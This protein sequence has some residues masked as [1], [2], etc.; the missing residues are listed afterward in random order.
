MAYVELAR[1]H[2]FL[3]STLA[4]MVGIFQAWAEGYYNLVL[5]A[6]VLVGLI[7]HHAALESWDELRDYANYRSELVTGSRAPPT[8]FSGGSG[9]LTG[10]LL[11]VGQVWCFFIAMAVVCTLVLAGIIAYTGWRVLL[12]VAL[13]VF[14]MGNYNSVLKLSYRGFGELANFVSFGPIVVCSAYLVLRLGASGPH[15]SAHGWDLLSFLSW[16]VVV[17]S[18]VLGAVWLG[19]EHIQG[20][21]D[22]EEDRAGGKQTLVVRFGKR[23]AAR[24]PVATAAAIVLLT[25][26]LSSVDPG[27]LVVLPA[28]VLHLCETVSFMRLWRDDAYFMR[29]L[30]S[31]FVYRNFALIGLS[32]LLSFFLRALPHAGAG[33][34]LPPLVVLT[35]ASSIPA[36]AFL[37]RN[38]VF[39]FAPA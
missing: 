10:G 39:A 20:M 9:V 26:Y 18:V 17:E 2:W 22:Y 21:L 34:D 16:P 31:Y 29:K 11:T 19:S 4:A 7:F 27:F 5:A 33:T 13:G 23:Y 3:T 36:S 25:V 6:L 28:A 8:L 12:C 32:I 1:P 15:G 38:R 14:F 35:V 30:R 24:V 37:A